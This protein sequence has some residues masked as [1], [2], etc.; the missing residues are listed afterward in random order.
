[1]KRNRGCLQELMEKTGEEERDR[2]M[3]EWRDGNAAQGSP[4]RSQNEPWRVNRN[5]LFSTK[6]KAYEKG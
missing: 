3:W 1:M 6:R 2:L 5:L 4:G